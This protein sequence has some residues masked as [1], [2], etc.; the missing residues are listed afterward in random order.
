MGVASGLSAAATGL[1]TLGGLN[2]ASTNA[3]NQIQQGQQTAQMDEFR[4]TQLQDA[5]KF[6]QAKASETDAFLRDRTMK[7]LGNIMAV[8]ASAN[9]GG[10]SPT[11][12][13]IA[14][15]TQGQE[16]QQRS[17]KVGDLQAQSAE[18]L[19]ESGMYTNAARDTLNRAYANANADE[20]GGILG[21]LGSLAKG[22]AGIS[23]G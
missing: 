5:A 20:T 14:A 2:T 3:Q 18:D 6:G 1:G 15:R 8:S 19:S 4:A 9:V 12:A 7:M 16:D 21:G 10:D 23:F 17:I 13:A 11:G 22:L